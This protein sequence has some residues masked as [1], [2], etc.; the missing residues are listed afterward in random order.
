MVEHVETSSIPLDLP[1]LAF[2]ADPWVNLHEEDPRGKPGIPNPCEE[3]K[4]G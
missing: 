4:E 2:L 3:R 1:N